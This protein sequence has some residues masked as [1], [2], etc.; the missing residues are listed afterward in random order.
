MKA[1]YFLLFIA[2]QA[3]LAQTTISKNFS[4]VPGQKI[5]LYFDYPKL[6]KV[7]TWEKNEVSITGSVSINDGEND[8][9]FELTSSS[10]GP[11]LQIRGEITNIKNLPH[12]ITIY[13]D[14]KKITFKDKS[15]Y[16]K[17]AAESGNDY[18]MM[19]T[20]IDIEIALEVKVPE[21][22]STLLK[23]VYGIVEVRNFQGPIE[24]EATYG[25]VDASLD[26]QSTG[27]LVAETNYG[28]IYSNLN[29]KFE[30]GAEKNFHSLIIARP[31]I[32]PKQ[33]FES[34]YGNVY[35]R[36]EL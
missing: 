4:V 28:Q 15:E 6:I 29:V 9:G 24:V 17:Y 13:R 18:S 11:V 25:G 16:K 27:E 31:G 10:T 35:L 20:G 22:S 26:A 14:G 1:T 8:D 34:K 30:G 21:N 3:C 36:K 32:G 12:R 19:N 23:S 7:S 2:G 5:S 33:S